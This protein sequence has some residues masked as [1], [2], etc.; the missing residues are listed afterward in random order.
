[1]N[2]PINIGILEGTPFLLSNLIDD[3]SLS[4]GGYLD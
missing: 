3:I 1:M 4:G 2:F